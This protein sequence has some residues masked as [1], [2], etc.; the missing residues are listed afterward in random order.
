MGMGWFRAVSHNP[1]PDYL[2]KNEEGDLSACYPM[3]SE[4]PVGYLELM[5]GYYARQVCLRTRLL[6]LPKQF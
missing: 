6:G 2:C 3:V 1:L 4:F 5:M